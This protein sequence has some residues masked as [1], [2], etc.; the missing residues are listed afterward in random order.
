M[1]VRYDNFFTFVFSSGQRCVF[2]V[3]NGARRI[4]II[5]IKLILTI[6]HHRILGIPYNRIPVTTFYIY[7]FSS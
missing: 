3:I 2:D 6:V 5:F 4:R 1:I 7:L